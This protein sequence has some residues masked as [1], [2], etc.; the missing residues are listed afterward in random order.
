ME[1]FET[2]GNYYLIS[3]LTLITGLSDRTI[4]N[5]I[6]GGI[7]RGEKINGLWHFTPEEVEHFMKHPAVLPSIQAKNNAIIYDFMLDRKKQNEEACIIL[8][9]PAHDPKAVA[10]HFCYSIST[11]GY[12]S[13]RF[14]FDHTAGVPRVI[15]KGSYQYIRQLVDTYFDSIYRKQSL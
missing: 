4:R 5:Y 1:P 9:L 6:A 13:I 3:H 7:L 14:A 11:G 8:D 12:Q 10:E 2:T 15:L